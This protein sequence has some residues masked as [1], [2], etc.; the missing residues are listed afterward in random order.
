MNHRRNFRIGWDRPVALAAFLILTSV[1]AAQQPAKQGGAATE[2][3]YV[4]DWVYKVKWG[5]A[6]E[7]WQLFNSSKRI[8]TFRSGPLTPMGTARNS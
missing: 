8:G 1:T 3:P 4:V 7:Y 6:D 2:K 5:H